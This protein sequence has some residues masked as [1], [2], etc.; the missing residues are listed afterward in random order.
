M[1][2]NETELKC[3]QE[4]IAW[5]ES[6]VRQFRLSVPAENFP[7][8]SEGY[9]AEIEKMHAEVMEYLSRYAGEPVVTGPPERLTVVANDT[10]LQATQNRIAQFQSWVA[11]FRQTTTPT[12]F[13]QMAGAFLAE[14][15][16]MHA[17][18][19]EYLRHHSSRVVPAEAA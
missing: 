11:Q 10:E 4:R 6:L 8:M 12:E 1:I 15:E 13:K 14:I 2:Q 7:A 16:K 9:L 17:E 5:F 3:T 18:K 19:M